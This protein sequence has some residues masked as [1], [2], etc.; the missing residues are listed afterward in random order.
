MASPVTWSSYATKEVVSVK[1]FLADIP[2]CF[3]VWVCVWVWERERDSFFFTF[4]LFIFGW[5]GSSLPRDLFSGWGSLRCSGWGSFAVLRLGLVARCGARA[6][7]HC[8]F[9]CCG[10][11]PTASLCERAWPRRVQPVS[12]VLAASGV[13]STGSVVVA[14]EL[15]CPVAHETFPDQGWNL[16]LLYWQMESLPLSHQGSPE[17]DTFLSNHRKAC[18]TPWLGEPELS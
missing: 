14:L 1:R 2:L 16:R 18:W 7:H 5:A 12:S 15:G 10:A 6:S 11:R 3:T 17:T 4:Y 13:W 8:G 9:P